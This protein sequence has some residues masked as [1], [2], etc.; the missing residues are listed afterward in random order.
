MEQLAE[1]DQKMLVFDMR[2][3]KIEP[4]ATPAAKPGAAS[5]AP[6]GEAVQAGVSNM[7]AGVAAALLPEPPIDAAGTGVVVANGGY[8]LTCAHVV[9]GARMILVRTARGEEF[10]AQ[11]VKTDVGND[12]CLLRATR[13]E[14]PPI[15][16]G[17]RK[18]TEKGGKLF[19]LGFAIDKATGKTAP[20]PVVRTGTVLETNGL[21]GDSRHVQM[22]MALG[23]GYSGSCVL[24]AQG[25]LAAVVSDKLNNLIQSVAPRGAVTAG[26]VFA[27]KAEVI[28]ALL[29]VD[30]R[31]EPSAAVATATALTAEGVRQQ[32][33]ESVVM[34]RVR[35]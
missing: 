16:W 28:A 21:D 12:W 33:A 27:Q 2:A 25:R 7:G 23:E 9:S 13:M 11:V 22:A 3:R 18:S 5:E 31:V 19:C 8:V 14:K 35:K 15:P 20:I 1:L 30:A 10:D 4:P 34:I 24:D 6:S 32:R 26:T 17:D 29:P